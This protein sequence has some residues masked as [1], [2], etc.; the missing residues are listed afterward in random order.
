MKLLFLIGNAA[1]G[2]STVQSKENRKTEK[3]VF[4]QGC[5]T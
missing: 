5:K 3:Q 1:V 2:K 4:A